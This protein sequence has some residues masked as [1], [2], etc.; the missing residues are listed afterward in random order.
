MK[1]DAGTKKLVR[2]AATAAQHAYAPYSHYRV[3]A[4]VRTKGGRIFTGGN[5]ENASY[6]LTICAERA[7]VSAAVAAGARKIIEVAVVA[8]GPA[9]PS[10]CGACRQVLAEF[11]GPDTPVHVARAGKLQAFCT[12]TLG[13]LLPETFKLDV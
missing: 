12:F 5:V 4:A 13:A 7:A 1:T 8:S 10:P 2:A 3:G 11:A 6:G 9:W